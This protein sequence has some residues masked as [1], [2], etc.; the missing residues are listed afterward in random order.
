MIKRRSTIVS[1]NESLLIELFHNII[2]ETVLNNN[3]I[4]LKKMIILL[5][6][7]PLML[8]VKEAKKIWKWRDG[9]LLKVWVKDLSNLTMFTNCRILDRRRKRTGR[10]VQ[11]FTKRK[12]IYFLVSLTDF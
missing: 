8:L 10:E 2:N 12:M 1:W 6:T 4:V 7:I 11:P 3:L 9:P 5:M